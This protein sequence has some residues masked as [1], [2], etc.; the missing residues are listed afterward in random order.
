M[1]K[2]YNPS[3]NQL[4]LNL[5]QDQTQITCG[6]T[7]EQTSSLIKLIAKQDISAEI[8]RDRAKNQRTFEVDYELG[9]LII[10]LSKEGRQGIPHLLSVD[11]LPNSFTRTQIVS[12][13]PRKNK[14]M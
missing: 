1:S 7:T 14:T 11:L 10:T 8:V 13:L 9:K 12:K 4:H 6:L 5:E 2:D 3:S